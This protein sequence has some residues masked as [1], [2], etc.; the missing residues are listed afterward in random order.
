MFVS[1]LV[2]QHI[3]AA[4]RIVALVHLL[5]KCDSFPRYTVILV[6]IV[7]ERQQLNSLVGNSE[8]VF[9]LTRLP[10]GELRYVQHNPEF[11]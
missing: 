10:R 4:N 1:I 8:R 7:S 6:C 9:Y 5:V 3:Q 2:L 11:T